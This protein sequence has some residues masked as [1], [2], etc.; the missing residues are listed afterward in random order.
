MAA[1]T[2]DGQRRR[3]HHRDAPA[4]RRRCGLAEIGSIGLSFPTPK[5]D[6]DGASPFGRKLQATRGRHGKPSYFADDGTESAMTESFFHTD[7]HGLVVAGFDVDHAVRRQ[8]GLRDRGCEE[9]RARH[10]PENF[11]LGASGNAGAE[12]GG[13]GSVD[14]AVSAARDFMQRPEREAAAKET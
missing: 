12:Q 13:G 7:E 11:A 5:S 6:A 9:I 1:D 8:A 4:G 14:R 2:G 10:A 3:W